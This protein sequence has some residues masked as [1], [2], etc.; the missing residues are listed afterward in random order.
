MITI[1]SIALL[2]LAAFAVAL[3]DLRRGIIP[4]WLNLEIACGGLSRSAAL[5]GLTGA[6]LAGCEG[7][8]VGAIAWALR[9]VYFRLRNLQ[10]LGL[11]DVKLLAASGVWIGI[12]GLPLQ[13]LV[14]SLAALGAAGVLKL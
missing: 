5:D 8:V 11:G 12:I 1:V 4:T 6:L 9:W 3:I 14:A 10:G 2:S 13:L 7:L